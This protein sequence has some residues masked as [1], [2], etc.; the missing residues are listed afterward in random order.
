MTMPTNI[1]RIADAVFLAVKASCAK[2]VDRRVSLAKAE[3]LAALPQGE[4]GG[5]GAPGER[6]EPGGP[7][8]PGERGEP[9]APGPQGPSG[10]FGLPGERGEPGEPGPQGL[11]GVQGDRGADGEDGVPGVQG[12]PGPQGV[13]GTAGMPGVPG[14]VGPCGPPGERG[15]PG[16]S[17]PQGVPGEKGELG[18]P[19]PRGLAGADGRDGRDGE[20]GRDALHIDVLEAIDPTKV[21][22]R[23]TFAKFQ[24]GIVRSF[25]TTDPAATQVGEGW[26]A[27]LEKAGWSVVVEGV[28][29]IEA[30]VDEEDVLTVTLVK[31]S[32]QKTITHKRLGTLKCRGV[33]KEGETY[34]KGDGVIRRGYWIARVDKPTTTPGTTEAADEWTLAVKN[35]RDGRDGANAMGTEWRGFYEDGQTYRAGSQVKHGGVVW[36]AKKITKEAPPLGSHLPSEVWEAICPG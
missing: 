31:T 32:G 15:A 14:D 13:P 18:T 23:G 26:F 16:D 8:A 30:L 34:W 20:P 28:A 2:E 24:G 10:G 29:S 27:K 3:M 17:G 11:Q 7:G 25:R 21:Y 12:E 19:G 1:D 4:P 22:P 36:M 6:G 5:P 33:F 35:G 9:G